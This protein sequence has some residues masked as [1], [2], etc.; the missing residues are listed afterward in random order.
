MALQS[1]IF[2]WSIQALA[3]AT[4]AARVAP[5]QFSLSMPCCRGVKSHLRLLQ[6]RDRNTNQG[7]G[8]IPIAP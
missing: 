5:E 6:M 8:S 4:S 2:C 7:K 3:S 1:R